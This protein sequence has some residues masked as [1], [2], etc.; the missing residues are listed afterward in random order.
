MTG[1]LKRVTRQES[2]KIYELLKRNGIRKP[3]N[4][5]EYND[6]WDDD[7]VAASVGPD[8]S[9]WSVKAIRSESFGLTRVRFAD[10]K[11]ELEKRVEELEK[12]VAALSSAVSKIS[13]QV[14]GAYVAK[15]PLFEPQMVSKIASSQSD[16]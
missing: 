15:T 6:G 16:F 5:Y 7:K 13:P 2:F 9:R 4:I 1:K 12:L 8:I 3:D 14:H 11:S 10:K